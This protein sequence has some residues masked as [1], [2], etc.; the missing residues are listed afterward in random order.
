MSLHELAHHVQKAGRNEDTQLVHMTPKEVQGLQS[1]AM[2]HGG[3]LT[4]N[5]ET[6]LP[7]AGF[8][9]SI[10]PM[11]AG[12]ALAATGVGAPIAALMVGGGMTVATGSLQKGLMAGLG[13]YGGAGLGASLAGMGEAAAGAGSALAGGITPSVAPAMAPTAIAPAMNGSVMANAMAPTASTLPQTLGT[14]FYNTAPAVLTNPLTTSTA[15]LTASTQMLKSIPPSSMW[16]KASAGM[17]QAMEHPMDFIK[18]NP[19]TAGSIGLSALQA[20]RPDDVAAKEN[21]GMIRPYTLER[22]QNPQAYATNTPVYGQPFDSS[23]R[24]YFTDKYTAGTPYAAPGPEYKANGGLASFAV[25]GP[26]EEMSAQ[27]AMSTNTGYPMAN[28]ETSVYANPQMSRPVSNNVVGASSDAGVDPYT[29]EARFAEGG[30]TGGYQ[31]SFNP[32]TQ[33]FTRTGSAPVEMSPSRGGFM[34]VGSA[35][36][37]GNPYNSSGII[38]QALR[39]AQASAP[40]EAPQVTGGIQAPTQAYQP[41]AYQSQAAA[42]PAVPAYQSPEQQLGLGGFY[43]YMDQQL[44][45]MRGYAEGGS[46]GGYNLGSYSDGG[47]LLRGPGDGVSDSIE[48]TI[49]DKQPARLADGEFVVPA[50]IVSELGNG[51][52]EAGARQLYKMM[53]RVQ[54]N[55]RKSVGKGKVAVDA[56]SS[57]YLPA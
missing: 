18:A 30:T 42:Q 57:K 16:D 17:Q 35:G 45:G 9:S 23:E 15:P 3:S 44:G 54:H 5:P 56:K 2:A 48:A 50:R 19:M 21:K 55:R 53:E 25:G 24:N 4:I 13:A 49:G 6:G 31:Y 37:G 32:Q 38:G 11:V 39:K 51:S 22:T 26:V 28:L 36:F 52:T 29:G 43:D 46:T 47:R 40:V 1:L 10:L 8:L 33:Q 41:P 14:G 12:A 20:M 27:N 34:G 7:E